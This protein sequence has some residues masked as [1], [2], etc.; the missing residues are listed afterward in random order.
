[1]PEVL[2]VGGFKF[3]IYFEDHEPR[4]VHVL[5]SG[6]EVKIDLRQLADLEA[7]IP[8]VAP[9]LAKVMGMTMKTARQALELVNE[10]QAKVARAMGGDRRCQT[11][12]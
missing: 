7:K 12:N 5:R 3:H 4:H 9:S 1:M 8:W 11:L 6:A 2:R 10:H